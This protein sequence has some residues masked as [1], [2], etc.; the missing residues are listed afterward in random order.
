MPPL[1]RPAC[2]RAGGAGR[3]ECPLTAASTSGCHNRGPSNG[4][5][6]AGMSI[7]TSSLHTSGLPLLLDASGA[8][9]LSPLEA[10]LLGACGQ[11]IA[12]LFGPDALPSA[13]KRKP[14]AEE[15][16]EEKEGVTDDD[17]ADEDVDDD[18]EDEEEDEDDA[19]EDDDDLDDDE[20]DEDDEDEDDEDEDDDFDDPDTAADDDDDDDDDDFEDDDE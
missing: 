17:D 2:G 6:F 15:E 12:H 10:S 20:D 1:C 3:S 14:K 19:L 11:S 5:L 16:E 8:G 4:P 13:A 18:E 9:L 7:M